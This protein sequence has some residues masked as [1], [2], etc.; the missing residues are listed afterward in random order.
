M[1]KDSYHSMKR[2]LTLSLAVHIVFLSW[3]AFHFTSSVSLPQQLEA[4]PITLAPL[5]ED[6]ASQQGALNAPVRA[7]PAVKPTIKPQEKEEAHHIGEGQIDNRAPFKPKEK[8]KHVDATPPPSEVPSGEK[9]ILEEPSPLLEEQEL[10]QAKMEEVAEKPAPEEPVEKPE[11][12]E[13]PAPMEP[14]KTPEV[15]KKT[16]PVEP[17]ETPEVAEKSAPVEPVETPEVA[18]KPAPVEPVEMPEVAEKPAPVEPVE[19]PEVAEKPAS[20]EPV[21]KPE[22]AEKSTPVEPVETLKNKKVTSFQKL[23][24]TLQKMPVEPNASYQKVHKFPVPEHFPH[25]NFKPKR[26][27]KSEKQPV[28]QDKHAQKNLQNSGQTIENILEMEEKDL[29]NRART[30]G[31]GAKRS[32]TPEALGAREKFLDTTKMAQTLVNIAGGCIQRKL[33]LVALGGDLKNRP[34]VRLQFY[35]NREGMVI[36]EPIITPLNGTESQQSIMIRQVY[37]A[38]FSCQPYTDLPRDQYDLWGQGFDFEVD[39]L[40][41]TTR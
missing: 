20:V 12:P 19:M 25:P 21:E 26:A 11:I 7:I 18:E 34:V 10:S 15:A 23:E 38:V 31:G 36:G 30:Q 5:S 37:V 9:K 8:P 27:K 3:G 35:L 29:L 40:Q 6:I 16:T 24:P 2:G 22:V 32:Q 39:P 28:L 1:N 13:K 33:K 4:I 41:E 17:V 14:V